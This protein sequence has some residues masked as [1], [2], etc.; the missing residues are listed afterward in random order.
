MYNTSSFRTS[1]SSQ[2]VQGPKHCASMPKQTFTQRF[3]QSNLDNAG[4]RPF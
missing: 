2:Q 1:F 4:K 3:H